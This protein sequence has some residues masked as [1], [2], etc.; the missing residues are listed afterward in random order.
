[1]KNCII[2]NIEL[3]KTQVKY[4]SNSC[5]SKAHYNKHVKDNTNTTYSNIID[6]L[7]KKNL[8]I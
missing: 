5:K 6:R 8:L 2:C 4:C 3:T 7:E 1:M